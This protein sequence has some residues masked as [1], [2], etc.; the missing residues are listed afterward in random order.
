VQSKRC[1]SAHFL[2]LVGNGDVAVAPAPAGNSFDL[3]ADRVESLNGPNPYSDFLRKHGH[4]PDRDQA[5]T[6]GRLMGG[7]VRASDGKMYP[8][9]SRHEM[10][11]IRAIKQR[12]REWSKKMDHVQR[13]LAAID[14][15]SQNQHEPGAVL[16][17]IGVFGQPN[18]REK[19]EIALDWLKRLSEESI[20]HD[21]SC[22]RLKDPG[23]N[24]GNDQDVAECWPDNLTNSI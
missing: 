10:T 17:Y 15:L 22:S 23:Q 7:R 5:T 1:K 4:R 21:K 13:T 16:S 24:F 11:A 14:A 18:I 20:R 12:R 8:E 9:L 19:L 6:V 2:R 3:E